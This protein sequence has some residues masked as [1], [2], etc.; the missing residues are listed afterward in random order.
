MYSEES[1]EH[2][3]S[4]F[5]VLKFHFYYLFCR[6][7]CFPF[8]AEHRNLSRY[9]ER[10][11][12]EVKALEVHLFLIILTIKS[13][14]KSHGN[15]QVKK[16]TNMN[17][18]YLQL[19]L[20]LAALDN[21]CTISGSAGLSHMLELS[22][23]FSEMIMYMR[24]HKC[25]WQN[26]SMSMVQITAD[27]WQKLCGI[28]SPIFSYKQRGLERAK[29]DSKHAKHVVEGAVFICRSSC[30]MAALQQPLVFVDFLQQPT[31]L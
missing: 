6:K 25:Q 22:L 9:L 14:Q 29:G 1:Q 3:F 5:I 31:F 23:Y 28:L 18:I 8:F 7:Y 15:L 26:I 10:I 30:R 17:I 11:L 12:L 27:S 24:I 16:R 4:I 20:R 2:I 21:H 19:F 13:F